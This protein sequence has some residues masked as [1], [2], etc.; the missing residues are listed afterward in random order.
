MPPAKSSTAGGTTLNYTGIFQRSTILQARQN[1]QPSPTTP[2][3]RGSNCFL[4]L[5]S[6]GE[7]DYYYE[8]QSTH[9]IV[10]HHSAGSALRYASNNRNC[11]GI[12]SV[13]KENS[14]VLNFTNIPPSPP[15]S[16]PK[17]YIRDGSPRE[18][19][20]FWC[21][22]IYV[23]LTLEQQVMLGALN[24]GTT[25]KCR[26]KRPWLILR[27]L[28]SGKFIVMCSTTREGKV[29]DGLAETEYD[30]FLPVHPT[31]SK[32]NRPCIQLEK[33]PEN[34]FVGMSLLYMQVE[35]EVS[36]DMLG[37][38]FA[39]ITQESLE[40]VRRERK[41]HGGLDGGLLPKGERV[42]MSYADVLKVR[43]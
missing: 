32:P 40:V 1:H 21:N 16:P 42:K 23:N 34:V 27:A 15:L 2:A 29:W 25:N 35:R 3:R 11:T 20:M 37:D 22:K 38:W 18:G 12:T 6:G 36:E 28:P 41:R 5:T 19:Q 8:P 13:E 31:P 39:E 10:A 17:L 9:N 4:V 26:K 14:G 33:D 30:N 24:P 43:S 7:D